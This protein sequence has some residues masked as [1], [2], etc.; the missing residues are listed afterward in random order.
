VDTIAEKMGAIMDTE[1][2]I[3]PASGMDELAAMLAAFGISME[4]D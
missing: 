2:F 4:S 1:D 3:I